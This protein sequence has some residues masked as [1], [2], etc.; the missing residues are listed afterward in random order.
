MT[1]KDT[2]S[3]FTD[4]ERE[5]MRARAE[6]IRAEKEQGKGAKKRAADRKKLEELIAS[7]PAPD[8]AAAARIHEII[9][10][11]AP[12]L[13]PRTWYGMPAWAL[14]GEVLC[15]FTHASKFEERYSSFGFN[16]PAQLDDGHMWATSFAVTEVDDE[17]ADRIAALVYRALG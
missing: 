8:R 11:V 5:A 1:E 13:D 15:F 9:G 16:A 7:M 12:Q 10:T 17:V 6:E 3:G 14:D 2:H 4:A